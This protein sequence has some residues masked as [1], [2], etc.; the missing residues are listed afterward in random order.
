MKCYVGSTGD[1]AGNNLVR[2][3]FYALMHLASYTRVELNDFI[4]GFHNRGPLSAM[5]PATA[6]TTK[7]ATARRP[8]CVILEA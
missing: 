4:I 2:E 6:S 5:N 3:C 8:S 1:P 7:Q